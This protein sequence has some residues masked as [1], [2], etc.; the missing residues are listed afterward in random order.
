MYKEIVPEVATIE[1]ER[2]E[3]EEP[4]KVLDHKV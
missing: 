2:E 3:I 4:K 1:E